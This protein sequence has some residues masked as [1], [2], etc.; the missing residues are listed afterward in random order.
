MRVYFSIN[1]IKELQQYYQQ[2]ASLFLVKEQN[3]MSLFLSKIENNGCCDIELY[4]NAYSLLNKASKRC[5]VKDKRRVVKGLK[6]LKEDALDMTE[7]IRLIDLI[8]LQFATRYYITTSIN[9]VDN[10]QKSQL[11]NK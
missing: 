10:E 9:V 8:R 11:L 4:N 5:K 2:I 1:R 7:K 6:N 3:E